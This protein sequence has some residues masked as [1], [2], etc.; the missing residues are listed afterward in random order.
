MLS[1]RGSVAASPLGR[2]IRELAGRRVRE[3]MPGLREVDPVAWNERATM[4]VFGLTE[5]YPA[6]W[7]LTPGRVVMAAS[8]PRTFATV[9]QPLSAATGVATRRRP[10]LTAYLVVDETLRTVTSTAASSLEAFAAAVAGAIRQWTPPERAVLTAAGLAEGFAGEPV[11][12]PVTHVG[13]GTGLTEGASYRLVVDDGGLHVCLVRAPFR[14]EFL[15]WGEI[16][17]LRVDVADELQ[18]RISLTDMAVLGLDMAVLAGRTTT[19]IGYLSAVT[20]GGELILRT[21]LAPPQLRAR[22]SRFLV[23][24]DRDGGGASALAGA[25]AQVAELHRSGALTDAEFAAAKARILG[26]P[27]GQPAG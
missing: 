2:S 25:L 9:C 5:G 16:D 18:R 20:S 27:G 8:A 17:R 4:A 11:E 6:V 19:S 22:L 13:G 24:H 7:A 23:R 12:L 15:P 1:G 21:E 26:D 14:A 10:V 3:V